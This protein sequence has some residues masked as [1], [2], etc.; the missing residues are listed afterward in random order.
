MKIEDIDNITLKYLDIDNY[1]KLKEVM[2]SA[3]PTM[4]TFWKEGHIKKLLSVF[5]EGQ[6]V[7]KIN[8]ELANYAL[9]I[10]IDYN[11]YDNAHTYK[12]ITTNDTFTSHQT[13]GDVLYG[14]D[15]FIKPEYRGLRL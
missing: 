12:N 7:I 2:I 3:Y 5:P 10:I 14:I 11:K 9:S 8:N 4:G 15:V 13:D 1:Q 6:V